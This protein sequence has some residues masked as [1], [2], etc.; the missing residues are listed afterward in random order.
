[1][2]LL[3]AVLVEDH[4]HGEAGALLALLQRAEVVGDALGQHRHDA[5]GEIDRVAALP[6]LAVERGAGAHVGGDIGDGDDDD[7]AAVIVRVGVGLGVD[8]V[9]VV[10]GVGRIDGDERQMR[11]I[12]ARASASAPWPLRLP[13]ARRPGSCRDA[14]GVDGDQARRLLVLRIAETGR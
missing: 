13:R 10:L 12:L 14:V 2:A 9:V 3:A 4:A 1:M 11:Q 6:R 8:R 5:V 7:E